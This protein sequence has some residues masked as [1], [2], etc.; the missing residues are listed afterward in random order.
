MEEVDSVINI[1]YISR[2]D[3]FPISHQSIDRSCLTTYVVLE[4]KYSKP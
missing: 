2:I 3:L 1:L 4:T